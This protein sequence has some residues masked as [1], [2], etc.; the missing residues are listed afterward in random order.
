MLAVGVRSGEVHAVST[1]KLAGPTNDREGGVGCEG[2]GTC[3][4]RGGWSLQLPRE[5]R[6]FTLLISP[7][8]VQGN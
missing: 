6:V 4:K 7:R 5:P 8:L 3:G 2:V 1:C